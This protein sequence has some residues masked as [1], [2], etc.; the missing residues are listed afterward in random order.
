M[1]SW[2]AQQCRQWQIQNTEVLDP[3]QWGYP[4]PTQDLRWF[5][6]WGTGAI[7]IASI[8]QK[9]HQ[10]QGSFVTTPGQS[11]S[12]WRMF[13][14]EL[15]G[16]WFKIQAFLKAGTLYTSVHECVFKLWV[17]PNRTLFDLHIFWD[18]NGS[19]LTNPCS[20]VQYTWVGSGLHSIYTF[21][22]ESM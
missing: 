15:F 18:Y 5:T 4:D 14:S 22:S 11:D 6:P 2:K 13:P 8:V 17:R 1:D 7:L 21:L 12:K 19:P 10:A 16:I 3:G 20:M 9:R